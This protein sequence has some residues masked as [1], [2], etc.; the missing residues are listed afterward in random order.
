M[1]KYFFTFIISPFSGFVNCID[2]SLYLHSHY[3]ILV[4]SIYINAIHTL[5]VTDFLRIFPWFRSVRYIAPI[6]TVSPVTCGRGCAVGGALHT[7][8]KFFIFN[9]KFP[10]RFRAFMLFSPPECLT[11]I[12]GFLV[13][14]PP[15]YWKPATGDW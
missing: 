11:Y 6:M 12:C 13:K 8:S 9:S 5:F 4:S 2:A 7:N 14:T 15:K 1:N 3:S 10:C